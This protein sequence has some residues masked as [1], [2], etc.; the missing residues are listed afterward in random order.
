M[1]EILFR[2]KR[3]E[4]SKWTY[5]FVIH[6]QKDE[7]WGITNETEYFND[8]D[9]YTIG[10]Y[11]GLID[12]NGVKIF[13]GDIIQRTGSKAKTDYFIIRWSE[14]ICGFTAGEWTR[15]WPNL[16]QATIKNYE[17]VGNIYDNPELLACRD[18]N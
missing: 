16:N 10:Q 5:G 17:V 6:A 1:R 18:N 4:D 11:T 12:G 9:G 15:T 3:L 13:E 7:S 2:G 14:A 8:V